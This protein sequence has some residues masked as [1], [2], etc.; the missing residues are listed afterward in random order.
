[1]SASALAACTCCLPLVSCAL[2]P[3]DYN[4]V[5]TPAEFGPH[6]CLRQMYYCGSDAQNHYFIREM[7]PSLHPS[8]SCFKIDKTLVLY[9]PEK[10][11]SPKRARWTPLT[12]WPISAHTTSR[13]T[14]PSQS[15]PK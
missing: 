12:A 6:S 14:R 8:A 11:F 5:T 3:G 4:P 7:T 15:L 2:T 10:P 13:G 1:M 9:A